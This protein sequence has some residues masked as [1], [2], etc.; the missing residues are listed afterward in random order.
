MWAIESDGD[1]G[2]RENK[3]LVTYIL[4]TAHIFGLTQPEWFRELSFSRLACGVHDK[5]Y[6]SSADWWDI[7]LPLA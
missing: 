5:L 1:G 6:T 7:L 4:Q 2:A 3:F